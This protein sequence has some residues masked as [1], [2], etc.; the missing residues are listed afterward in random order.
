MLDSHP[1]MAIPPESHFIP[2]LLRW[3]VVLKRGGFLNVD[4]FLR[5]LSYSPWFKAWGLEP[6]SV[7]GALASAPTVP[8]AIVRLFRLYADAQGK[9]RFGDKTPNH[10]TH[11]ARLAQAFPQSVFVHLLRDPRDVAPALVEGRFW[12]STL[13]Q[14]AMW[15]RKH[16]DAARREGRKLG[17]SRYL[18]VRYEDLVIEPEQIL[19]GIC[20]FISLTY[21]ARMLEYHLRSPE[22]LS[23]TQLPE[24][25]RARTRHNHLN[26]EPTV[27]RDWRTDLPLADV[28]QIEA[29]AGAT[30]NRFGYAPSHRASPL[31]MIRT[32]VPAHFWWGG[33][34]MSVWRATAANIARRVARNFTARAT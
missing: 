8:E 31:F 14:A 26:R 33:R 21:S 12:P 5:H 20:S 13:P 6:A 19:Q 10:S 27:L 16:S 1:D 29:V 2:H 32:A 4:R 24:F 18:E 15:W 9:A 25:E 22:I 30:A 34:R 23:F 3:R 28:R 17:E 11:V 7:R